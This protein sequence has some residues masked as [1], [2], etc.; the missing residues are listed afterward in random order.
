MWMV[1]T[2]KAA[3][4]AAKHSMLFSFFPVSHLVNSASS[5]PVVMMGRGSKQAVSQQKDIELWAITPC[6]IRHKHFQLNLEI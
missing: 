5:F 1:I 2:H 4:N 3:L 6:N